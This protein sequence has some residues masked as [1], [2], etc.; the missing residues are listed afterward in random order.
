MSSPQ[1]RPIQCRIPAD[2]TL[3]HEQN[4]QPVKSP[5]CLN[6]WSP[7][8]SLPK[9]QTYIQVNLPNAGVVPWKTPHQNTKSNDTYS[10]GIYQTIDTRFLKIPHMNTSPDNCASMTDS[11][12]GVTPTIKRVNSNKLHIINTS[13][14][15]NNSGKVHF[16]KTKTTSLFKENSQHENDNLHLSKN[17]ESESNKISKPLLQKPLLQRANS[18]RSPYF[19]TSFV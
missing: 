11:I 17:T 16:N 1:T 7:P 10:Q 4:F 3:F 2:D 5:I 18:E 15:N 6:P 13:Q 19:Q 12:G 14:E 8:R 9:N